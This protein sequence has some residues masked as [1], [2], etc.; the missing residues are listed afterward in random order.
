MIGEGAIRPA[1]LI[2]IPLSHYCEKARWALDRLAI[3]YREKPHAPLLSRVAGGTVPVLVHGG[4]RFTDSRAILVRA[5]S[6][7]GG[8]RLYPRVSQLRSEVDALEERFDEELGPHARRWIYAQLLPHTRLLRSL[9]SRG[10]PR[11]EASLVPLI[12]PLARRL[13]RTSYKIT[14]EAAQRS[15]ERVRSVFREVDARLSDG[16]QYLTGERFTAADL[17]FA[18]LAAPMLLPA[19]CRAVQPVFDEVPAVMRDEILRLRDT[20]AG[21]FA[22][23]MYSQERS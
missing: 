2:T 10:V 6:L 7:C 22:L 11:V 8:D 17:T 1:V 14:A 21:R 5:D 12:V 3:P 19:E 16:R 13:V 15:L 20:R 4:Q 9:W 23:Q 18:A